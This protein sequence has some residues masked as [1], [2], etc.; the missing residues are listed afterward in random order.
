M[1]QKVNTVESEWNIYNIYFGTLRSTL[2]DLKAKFNCRPAVWGSK[3]LV[4]YTVFLDI[5]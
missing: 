5:E 1:I 4:M 3:P 2:N